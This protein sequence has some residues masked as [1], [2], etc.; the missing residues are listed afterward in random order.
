MSTSRALQLFS[1]LVVAGCG[2]LAYEARGDG[3]ATMDALGGADAP[4]VDAPSSDA[5]GT[6]APAVDAPLPDGAVPRPDDMVLVPAGQF[7]MGSDPGEGASDELPEHRVVLSAYYFDRHEVTNADYRACVDAGACTAPSTV[8]SSTRADY[9][10]NPAYD[11]YPVIRVSWYQASDYCAWR[12]K[13]LP[14]EAEWEMAARGACDVVAPASCGPED[15]R[16]FPWGEAPP[17]C[18]LANFDA[19]G[20]ACVPGGDTDAVGARS[21]A[22]DSPYGA[23]DMS[24]NVFEWV[25]DWYFWDYSDC[26]TGCTNPTGAESG[27]TRSVRSG[28]WNFDASSARDAA[29]CRDYPPEY[30]SNFLG[31]RC[32]MT[33]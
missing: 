21:P 22:G 9:F 3:G 13:R 25:A 26:A 4:G 17:S 33:P 1:L 31:I 6:D 11:A 16:T 28:A 27:G 8:R 15:E 32:A 12:G 18:A 14:T 2:R 29:R 19:P 7:V 24:G 20:G 30:D 5:R 23:Q 10:T